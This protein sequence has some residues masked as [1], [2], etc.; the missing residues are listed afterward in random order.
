M[1][2]HTQENQLRTPIELLT[3]HFH[4]SGHL[5]LVDNPGC[6][7]CKQAI[8]TVSD[9]LWNCEALITLRFKHLGQHFMKPGD[10]EDISVSRICTLFKV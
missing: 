1:E 8:E 2:Y 9:V 6:G 4:L 3:G 5:G 10:F 7:R